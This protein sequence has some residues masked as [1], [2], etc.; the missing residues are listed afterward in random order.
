[1]TVNQLIL[2]LDIHR[3]YRP[4]IHTGTPRG[5]AYRLR[6]LG[7]IDLSLQWEWE[8]TAEGQEAVETLI[9]QSKW[10]KH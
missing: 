2:L 9:S 3:G 7:L 10:F 4:E 5:D 6:D 1:M 8:L